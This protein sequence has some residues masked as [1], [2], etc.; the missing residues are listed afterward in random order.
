MNKISYI[1][2][3]WKNHLLIV[4]LLLCGNSM[5]AQDKVDTVIVQDKVDTIYYNKDGKGVSHP[6]FADFYRLALY[7]T[8]ENQKKPFR[9]YFIS[10][11]LQ[12]TGNFIS[13]DK[14]DDKKSVFDEECIS[15][16]RNGKVALKRTFQNGKLNGEFCEYFED[17]LIKE[18]CFFVDDELSG[19]YTV[20]SED[21]SFMQA[22]YINGNPKYEYYLIG[23]KNG[24]TAKINFSDNKPLWES[25]SAKEQEIEYRDG[26]TWQYYVKNGLTIA[27]RTSKR[28]GFNDYGRFHKVDI[29]IANN[30]MFEI[31]FDPEKDII[32]FSS[33]KKG[34]KTDL[35]VWSCEMYMKKVQN[36]QILTA[37][38]SGISEGLATA[39]AG[40]STSTTYSNSYYN[41]SSN[42][43][44][45]AF[46]YGSG[47]YASGSYYGN[48]LYNGSSY[49]YSTTTT[50][51]AAAAY[52][53]Q[54]L[55]QQRMSNLANAMENEQN[56]KRMG[57]LKKNTIYPGETIQGHVYVERIS[58]VVFYVIIDISGAKYIYDWSYE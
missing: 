35:T 46:S 36:I 52:Q 9:D 31:E 55:S 51:N 8:D 20:F 21:N 24:I 7:P 19:L 48:T 11:E 5:I 47:G 50:Y 4:I 33:N 14:V 54:V 13:I 15:Y 27:Q 40:Y 16:F 45:N 49:T 3:R 32:A 39:N 34:G 56:F 44:G 53:A 22:E 10:G 29:V 2:K 43:Y 57:Y 25:P 1:Q 38:M 30:S 23:N 28:N 42:S 58:C 41:G 18:K 6:A 26:I 37:V 17:G 12:T